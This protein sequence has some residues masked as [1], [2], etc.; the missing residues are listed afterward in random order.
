M[1]AV[2]SE[3]GPIH[4]PTNHL[5]IIARRKME[6]RGGLPPQLKC[7]NSLTRE[8]GHMQSTNLTGV[9]YAA[10]QMRRSAWR[11]RTCAGHHR[12]YP[13]KRRVAP[14]DH[15]DGRCEYERLACLRWE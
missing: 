14:S 11:G 2:R 13:S 12:I 8:S 10:R 7:T 4:R 3:I 5:A 15:S 9:A 6:R 1:L